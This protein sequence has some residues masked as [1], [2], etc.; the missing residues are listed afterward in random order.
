MP[1]D[2]IDFDMS[3]ALEELS[4]DFASGS[5]AGD[6]EADGPDFK[7]E[8]PEE[9]ALEVPAP[10]TPE[11]H[12]SPAA[13]APKTWRAEAAASWTSLPEAAR[14][15][16]LKREDDIFRG[17]EGYKADA[18]FGKS[19]KTA[20]DPFLP[21]LSQHGIDPAAQV[22]RLMQAHHTLALGTAE[23][24]SALFQRLASDY[25]VDLGQ[26]SSEAPFVDPAVASLRAELASVKSTLSMA[27]QARESAA[28][29]EMEKTVSSFAADPANLH[30]AEVA[31]DM[32][33]LLKS[34]VCG[35]L[36][37][38]YERA[39][40]ANPA[41]RAKEII[42]QQTESQKALDAERAAKL[43]EAKRS[44]AANVRTRAK[45]GGDTTPKGSM[46]ETLE[47]AYAAI[48]SRS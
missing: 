42:R 18:A 31:N 12:P 47:A 11:T 30:F 35:D 9:K 1:G 22:S 38:A 46:D 10:S 5:S 33:I 16:I 29:K 4:A 34:G 15:E 25:G 28:T 21:T 39:I 19:F 24:K 40:W 2:D 41:T 43:A 26:L 20:L 45:Q 7:V 36:K 8:L 37:S 48:T 6:G 32:A 17:I 23:Q 14:A 27:E 13:S 3:G 44:S